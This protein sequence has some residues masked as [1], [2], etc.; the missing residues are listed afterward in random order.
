MGAETREIRDRLIAECGRWYDSVRFTHEFGKRI[1]TGI[2]AARIAIESLPDE[3][4]PAEFLRRALSVLQSAQKSVEEPGDDDGWTTGGVA[5]I[6]RAVGDERTR[7]E[8]ESG[9]TREGVLA[10]VDA[11]LLESFP[12]RHDALLRQVALMLLDPPIDSGDRRSCSW[13]RTDEG[14]TFRYPSDRVVCEECLRWCSASLT[15]ATNGREIPAP[16][17]VIADVTRALRASSAPA[18]ERI[19]HDLERRLSARNS[20]HPRGFLPSCEGC[21]RA[22]ERCPWTARLPGIDLCDTCIRDA[23]HAIATYT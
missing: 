13:C 2:Q 12:D 4:E 9:S 14:H 6:M 10:A 1:A 23:H 18:A 16:G 5:T 8:R 21:E 3:L 7:L 22:F 15:A 19:I 20:R 11:A 17:M